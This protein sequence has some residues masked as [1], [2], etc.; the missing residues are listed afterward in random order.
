[1]CPFWIKCDFAYPFFYHRYSEYLAAAAHH[2]LRFDT[3]SQRQQS[4][5]HDDS[6]QCCPSGIMPCGPIIFVWNNEQRM[7][8]VHM[9]NL[10]INK[11]KHSIFC[12]QRMPVPGTVFSVS[13]PV[14]AMMCLLFRFSFSNS[15]KHIFMR[16][17]SNTR[18]RCSVRSQWC[19][20]D[21]LTGIIS[22]VV[23]LVR[24]NNC[25]T[26]TTKL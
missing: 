22:R 25:P 9:Y 1:M 5:A 12:K 11:L 7:F 14:N 16:H 6:L 21:M 2:V 4:P 17:Q 3:R 18:V 24:T 15:K 13:V 20:A 8:V 26:V 23:R 10:T 19:F